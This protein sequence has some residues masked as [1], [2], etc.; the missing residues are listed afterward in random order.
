MATPLED[1][2]K[3]DLHDLV[4]VL[5]RAQ[6]K[7][8]RQR[9]L[10]APDIKH[11]RGE[12]ERER[13]TPSKTPAAQTTQAARGLRPQKWLFA[14]KTAAETPAQRGAFSPLRRKFIWCSLRVGLMWSRRPP[15]LR[16]SHQHRARIERHRHLTGPAP[17]T[18]E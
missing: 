10:V 6:S 5:V 2:G 14:Q 15:R 8:G 13:E 9:L 11:L 17:R 4:D 16:L 1:V 7:V 12:R 3:Q 18:P